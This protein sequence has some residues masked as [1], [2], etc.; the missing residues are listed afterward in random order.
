MKV[1][2]LKSYLTL[3]AIACLIPAVNAQFDDVYYDPD[4]V[5]IGNYDDDSYE[6]SEY[7]D[8]VTYYDD[9]EYEYY[10]DYDYYYTSRIRRFHHYTPGFDFYDPWYTSYSYYNPYDYDAYF[11]PGASI[12]ISFG[13]AD[14][15]SYR[16][17]RR[18]NR[19]NRW[20]SYSH[21]SN[22]HFTPASYYYS[23]NSW[24]APS[25]NYWGGHHG[26]HSYSNYYNN[27]YNS[28]PL[29]ISNY[30]GVTHST[31]NNINSGNTRGSYYG[32][33]TSGNTGSSPRGPVQKP[34][35]IQPVLSETPTAVSPTR[36]IETR[37]NPLQNEGVPG[38][39]PRPVETDNNL[40]TDA[41]SN[42]K[43]TDGL[44]STRDG[45]IRGGLNREPV[46]KE[47]SR[48]QTPPVSKRPVFKPYPTDDRPA[49]RTETERVSP[50]PDRSSGTDRQ[51]E[52]PKYTPRSQDKTERPSYTPPSS[53][54]K[55]DDDSRYAP[56]N[57]ERPSYTPR[58]DRAAEERPSYTPP[59]RS[60]RQERPSYTPSQRSNES[61]RSNDR[62]SY[63]PPS[64]N[65]SSSGGRSASPAPS[66]DSSPRSS[67]SGKSP[68]SP[69]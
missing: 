13:N 16:N 66:R 20:N 19:W 52:T 61:S 49:T 33:R 56:R 53:K 5:A 31:V 15:W 21:W 54:E 69:R 68:R 36:N 11:Y 23:Y 45:Q 17:W 10:D 48:E 46:D 47:I 67:S 41:I 51:V 30:Y 65:D 59:S 2:T 29:P 44:P 55:R 57:D 58:N 43:P 32:P 26:Y 6:D 4:N 35:H 14:Y 24:C 40:P 7:N 25:Y 27:Y 50:S 8:D 62:P 12:Y 28:C 34:E 9:D 3:L 60:E 64:R 38:V 37:D 63:S 22:W 42:Q 1:Y 18:Y 39:R